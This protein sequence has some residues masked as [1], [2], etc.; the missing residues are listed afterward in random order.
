MTTLQRLAADQSPP[1]DLVFIDADKPGYL[2][3]LEFLLDSPLLAPGAVIAVDNTLLQGEPY[4]ADERDDGQR[5]RD[6]VVQRRGDRRSAGGTGAA[7][8]A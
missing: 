8:V 6:C 2:G 5:C 4:G 3:Y 7:A 1:F